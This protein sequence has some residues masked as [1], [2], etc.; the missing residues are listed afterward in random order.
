MQAT[1][2]E[3]LLSI[4]RPGLVDY[5]LP[6]STLSGAMQPTQLSYLWIFDYASLFRTRIVVGWQKVV[7]VMAIPVLFT[8]TA[9]AVPSNAVLM[10][11]RA[12]SPW[13]DLDDTKYVV[14]TTEAVGWLCTKC[15]KEMTITRNPFCLV[16]VD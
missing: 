14:V 6:L 1:I 15:E 4:I 9:L 2:V 10:N 16:V 13:T 5:L 11:P 7:F 3:V 8:L 12:G